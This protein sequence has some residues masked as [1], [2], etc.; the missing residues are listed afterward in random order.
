MLQ[1]TVLAEVGARNSEGSSP[2]VWSSTFTPFVGSSP[3]P[4]PVAKLQAEVNIHF[5]FHFKN[6]QGHEEYGDGGNVLTSHSGFN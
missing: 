1:S 4:H 6:G 2:Y 5:C 3:D